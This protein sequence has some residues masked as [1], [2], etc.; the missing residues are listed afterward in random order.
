MQRRWRNVKRQAPQ[1]FAPG[2]DTQYRF[3][4]GH[5]PAIAFAERIPGGTVM[6]GGARTF[7][8]SCQSPLPRYTALTNSPQGIAAIPADPHTCLC[9]WQG[10]IPVID[11]FPVTQGRSV[12]HTPDT[13]N[14]ILITT[15]QQAA[16]RAESEGTNPGTVAGKTAPLASTGQMPEM[17]ALIGTARGNEFGIRPHGQRF[18]TATCMRGRRHQP[19][20]GRSNRRALHTGCQQAQ[21]QHDCA[22]GKCHGRT[23]HQG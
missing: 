8:A 4:R 3:M 17:D 22:Y 20:R 21:K 13:H 6:Q 2:I 11:V 16:I 19:Q 23:L 5:C 1:N 7:S 14:T 10:R 18:N 9:G 12:C 15:R